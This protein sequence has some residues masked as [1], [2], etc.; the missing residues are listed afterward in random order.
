MLSCTLRL[1]PSILARMV[2]L[3][4]LRVS[5]RSASCES[6]KLRPAQQG[7]VLECA[8][9]L[10]QCRGDGPTTIAQYMQVP[11]RGSLML[12]GAPLLRQAREFEDAVQRSAWSTAVFSHDSEHVATVS[13]ARRPVAKHARTCTLNGSGRLSVPRTY[14]TVRLGSKAVSG[15]AELQRNTIPDMSR[16]L[17]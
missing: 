16:L 14:D 17:L 12:P 11:G 15:R 10:K 13:Q 9:I 3:A 8:M 4:L 2:I 5:V 1:Q 6:L 7:V